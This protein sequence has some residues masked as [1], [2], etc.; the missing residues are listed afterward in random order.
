MVNTTLKTI[1]PFGSV[2]AGGGRGSDPFFIHQTPF[3]FTN[4]DRRRAGQ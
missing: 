4:A 3:S 2:L 1:T